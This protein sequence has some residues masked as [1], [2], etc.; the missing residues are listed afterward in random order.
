MPTNAAEEAPAPA[1]GSAVTISAAGRRLFG[2]V[3]LSC[4]VS[5]AGFLLPLAA[6]LV[7]H[8]TQGTTWHDVEFTEQLSTLF[9]VAGVLV[10]FGAKWM[11]LGSGAGLGN[12]KLVVA[13]IA[14]D[15]AASGSLALMDRAGFDIDKRTYTVIVAACL[16]LSP[17]LFA[18]YLRGA[19]ARSGKPK[20]VASSRRVVSGVASTILWWLVT[21][22]ASYLVPRADHSYQTLLWMFSWATYWASG[23]FALYTLMFYVA[24][25]AAFAATKLDPA[26]DVAV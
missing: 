5:A 25:L 26:P 10:V 9:I 21:V 3:R 14:L 15:L 19:A 22:A 20:L 8:L 4:A 24:F 6:I 17:L 7:V 2:R 13:A 23:L 16:A 11:C 18:L 12:T 1:V